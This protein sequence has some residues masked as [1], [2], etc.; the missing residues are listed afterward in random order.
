MAE[1]TKDNI[2]PYIETVT[3]KKFYFLNPSEDTISIMD[4]AHALSN[5]CRY[6]GHSSRF[7]SVAEHCVAVSQLTNSLAGLLHDASEAYLT[8]VASPVKP[9]L[10]NY[11]TLE[12]GIMAPIA[13]KYRIEWPLTSDVHDADL[14]QLSTEA[15]YLIPSKGHSWEW[16]D[17]AVAGRPPVEDGIR[18]VGYEPE[19]A[20]NLF[21]S[22]FVEL[23]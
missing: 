5:M 7:F 12:S 18:P 1:F 17:W 21:L 14:Q 2:A 8:D 6:T 13:Q 4:I 20:K 15:F 9:H 22:R 11:R 19:K 16:G 3:G 10:N 23:I